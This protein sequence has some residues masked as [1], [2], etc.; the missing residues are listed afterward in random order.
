MSVRA[1]KLFVVAEAAILLYLIGI[2][3]YYLVAVWR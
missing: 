2:F 3:Y 1:W